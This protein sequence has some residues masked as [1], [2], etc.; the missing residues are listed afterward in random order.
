M[1]EDEFLEFVVRISNV[2]YN[3]SEKAKTL[4]EKIDLFLVRLL[5]LIKALKYPPY[6]PEESSEEDDEDDPESHLL[7]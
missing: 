3:K 6:V 1:I 7:Q 4:P 2:I 5:G